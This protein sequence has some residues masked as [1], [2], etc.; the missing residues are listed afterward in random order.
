MSTLSVQTEAER[1]EAFSTYNIRSKT[2]RL[3]ACKY[4]R[5]NIRILFKDFSELRG[6][7]KVKVVPFGMDVD[8]TLLRRVFLVQY[9]S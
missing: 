3:H 8:N 7:T 1:R 5:K 9:R 2:G 4:I 6:L